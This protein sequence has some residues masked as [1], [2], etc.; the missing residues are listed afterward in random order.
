MQ[1][2]GLRPQK[3]CSI[4]GTVLEIGLKSSHGDGHEIYTVHGGHLK[5]LASHTKII[6]YL[7]LRP[8]RMW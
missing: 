1:T 6:V 4:S 2:C 3:A 7:I 5:A 8:G